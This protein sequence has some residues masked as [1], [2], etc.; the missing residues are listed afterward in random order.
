MMFDKWEFL[1]TLKEHFVPDLIYKTSRLILVM[2]SPHKDEMRTRIP[3]SGALGKAVS[4]V[5]TQDA[6]DTPFGLFL[7]N[8]T[9]SRYG[10]FN[11]VPMPLNIMAYDNPTKMQKGFSQLREDIATGSHHEIFSFHYCNVTYL[12]RLKQINPNSVLFL[13]GRFAQ[14]FF[15]LNNLDNRFLAT[16]DLPHPSQGHWYRNREKILEAIYLGSELVR[17]VE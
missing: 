12:K 1:E 2:E 11:T 6:I 5:I 8:K 10:I 13:C 4:K 9:N 14:N 15:K 7:K 17:K 3:L 16:I